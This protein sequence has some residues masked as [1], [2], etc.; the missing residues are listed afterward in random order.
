MTSTITL[1]GFG[2]SRSFRA[3]WALE[4]AGLAYQYV[5]LEFSGSGDNGRLSEQYLSLNIQGKVP[6]LVDGDL[7][8]SESAAI[9]NYIASKVKHLALKPEDGTALR[10]KYDEICCFILCEL[11]QPL[12]TKGKHKFALP[13]EYRVPEIITKTLSFEFNKAQRAL[14]VLMDDRNFAVGDSFSMA[15]VMLVQTINWAQRF[16]FELDAKLLTYRDLH[17]E[18]TGYLSAMATI[19]K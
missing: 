3:L 16:E 5:E 2:S 17:I 12:W 9:V 6:T 11:E 13:E 14:L 19:G 7:I 1:Y 4:E 18:R 10:A 8:I 15:D